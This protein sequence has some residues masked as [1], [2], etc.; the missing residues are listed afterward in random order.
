MS[1]CG[2]VPPTIYPRPTRKHNFHH[3]GNIHDRHGPFASGIGA[4]WP[5]REGAMKARVL[6][7]SASLGPAELKAAYKAFDD[8]WATIADRYEGPHAIEA[9]RMQLATL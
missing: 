5:R 8:A 1:S 7:E 9:A 2:L 4:C 3:I 6:I